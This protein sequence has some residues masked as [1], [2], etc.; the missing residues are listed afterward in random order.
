M[1][2]VV[3][4]AIALLLTVTLV[5]SHSTGKGFHRVSK[6]E[7][8]KTGTASLSAT[9][10]VPGSENK[11]EPAV[12][13]SKQTTEP[14]TDASK[15]QTT[16]DDK[17]KNDEQTK[18]NEQPKNDDQAKNNDQTKSADLTTTKNTN[19]TAEH[20]TGTLPIPPGYVA[21][22]TQ[23]PDTIVNGTDARTTW[24]TACQTALDGIHVDD[25]SKEAVYGFF[26][27]ALFNADTHLI[28]LACYRCQNA[29]YDL[30][31]VNP[32]TPIANLTASVIKNL[33]WSATPTVKVG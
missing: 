8:T 23:L 14:T 25:T 1:R 22:L 20:H 10:S 26:R 19:K 18:K 9:A 4:T 6:R 16:D 30:K 24:K 7:D 15:I 13:D 5:S 21:I 31:G 29:S 27:A 32:G 33:N 3:I 11:V 12:T 2:F 28:E 17:T